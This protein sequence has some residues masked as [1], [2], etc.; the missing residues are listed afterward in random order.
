MLSTAIDPSRRP[1]GIS[2]LPAALA[3]CSRPLGTSPLLAILPPL[4]LALS[5]R[6]GD[7]MLPVTLAPY[8]LPLGLD[9]A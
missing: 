5:P 6:R 1:L 9:Y 3:P 2:P 8:R 7:K 4:T